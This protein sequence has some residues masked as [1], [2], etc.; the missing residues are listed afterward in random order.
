[1]GLIPGLNLAFANRLCEC[2]S[3]EK[4]NENSGLGP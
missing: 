1:L 4:A 2:E 3:D